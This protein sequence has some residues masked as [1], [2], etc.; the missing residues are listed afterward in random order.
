MLSKNVLLEEKLRKCVRSEIDIHSHV[1]HDNITQYV[2][3]FCDE[4]NLYMVL[5]L[6][7]FKSLKEMQR[8]RGTITEIEC[9]YFLYEILKGVRY[10]HQMKIVH[11]DLKLSN[12][13]LGQNMCVKIGDFGLAARVTTPDGLLYSTCGT[14]NYFSPEIVKKTGYSYEVDVW[15]IGVI[16]YFLLV[17]KPPFEGDTMDE[18]FERIEECEYE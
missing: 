10:L 9:R 17:G 11:R 6:C 14:A 1:A 18:L 7:P 2:S 15:C 4:Y 16:M 12:I 5:E 8:T 3:D 13:F